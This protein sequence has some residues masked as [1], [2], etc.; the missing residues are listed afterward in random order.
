[1][2]EPQKWYRSPAVIGLVLTV[3][4]FGLFTLAAKFYSEWLLSR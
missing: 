3:A 4:G 2:S 1:M